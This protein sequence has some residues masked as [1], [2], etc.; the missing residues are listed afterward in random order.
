M[1][2]INYSK[3]I[4]SLKNTTGILTPSQFAYVQSNRARTVLPQQELF[5]RYR[6]AEAK[7]RS[8]QLAYQTGV[9]NFQ[10]TKQKIADDEATRKRLTQVSEQ[11]PSIMDDGTLSTEEQIGAVNKLLVDNPRVAASFP[12]IGKNALDTLQF[13]AVQERQAKVDAENERRRVDAEERGIRQA[14][15]TVASSVQSPEG[16][17]LLAKAQEDYYGDHKD[18]SRFFQ[19][20]TNILSDESR[21]ASNIR[22]DANRAREEARRQS[23]TEDRNLKDLS[24][25]EDSINLLYDRYEAQTQKDSADYILEKSQYDGQTT[26]FTRQFKKKKAQEFVDAL[27]NLEV[28]FSGAPF[29]LDMKKIE[30]IKDPVQQVIEA[31]RQLRQASRAQ[32]KPLTEEEI[33]KSNQSLK[34]ANQ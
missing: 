8:D 9:L 21:V 26:D 27:R 25:Y 22:Q 3:D 18:S 31:K 1:S 29:R 28:S 33:Q 11:L 10:A 30:S 34:S 20:I 32:P 19:D 4:G 5:F 24:A 7:R 23:A 2:E 16:Q 12:S 6:D 15:L 13:K 17:K 14:T